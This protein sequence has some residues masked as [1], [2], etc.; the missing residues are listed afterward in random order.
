MERLNNE[1]VTIRIESFITRKHHQYPE[2]SLRGK[3]KQVGS[4]ANLITNK[5]FNLVST[6]KL[7]RL[8]N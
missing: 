5:L 2:L 1:Q 8:V 4:F 6:T 3:E 7:T